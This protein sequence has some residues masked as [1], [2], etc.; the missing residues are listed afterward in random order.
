MMLETELF[1]FLEGAADGSFSLPICIRS[2]R[3]LSCRDTPCRRSA[4]LSC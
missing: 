3:T 2:C 4:N 1:E